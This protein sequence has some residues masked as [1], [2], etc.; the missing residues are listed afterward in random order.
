VVLEV[1]KSRIQGKGV[2]TS[3]A[4]SKG[5]LVYTV[6]VSCLS[7]VAKPNW[8]CIGKKLWVSD[9]R[10]LNWVNHSCSPST[11]L[12]TA[13]NPVLVAKRDIKPG[14]EIT[15]DYCKTER[16]GVKVRC[17]CKSENCKGY[18]LRKE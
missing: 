18:F 3:D 6:P 4:F 10:V 5:D 7:N 11:V 17:L 15:V 16:G 13:K 12:S 8:A 9:S 2:F 14:E 1:R